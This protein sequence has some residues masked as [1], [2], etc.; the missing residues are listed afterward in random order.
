MNRQTRLLAS[1][2]CAFAGLAMSAAAQTQVRGVIA[3]GGTAA[4]SGGTVLVGSIGQPII[5]PAATSG[6]NAG[7]GFWYAVELNAPA[8]IDG[9]STTSGGSAAL[10]CSP[11]PCAS[12]TT[13]RVGV[14]RSGRVRV[15]LFDA[16]GNQART[17]IDDHYEA[18]TISLSLATSD[19]A[20][21]NYVV[22]L[23]APGA[24][25]A[26]RIVVMK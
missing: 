7:Q 25:D 8:A 24:R 15:T 9:A 13:L 5:G 3:S 17:I 21:G 1:T 20:S 26:V 11:N 16:L 18:G 4:A 12:G 22:R 19:L 23:D 14:P 2:L 6:T 10:A